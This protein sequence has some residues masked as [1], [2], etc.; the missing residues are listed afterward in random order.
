MTLRQYALTLLLKPL[1][2]IDFT[3]TWCGP[4]KMI[5]PVYE[6]M[7]EEFPGVVFAKIDV[8]DN[9]EATQLCGVTAMPTFQFYKGGQKVG[10]LKGAN[11]DGLRVRADARWACCAPFVL[12]TA[13]VKRL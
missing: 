10:E 8:D 9:E 6:K 13:T 3:A 5:A 1:V 11:A 4:C 7:Q 12:R 2:I